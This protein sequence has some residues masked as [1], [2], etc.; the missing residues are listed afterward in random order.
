MTSDIFLF[1]TLRYRPLLNLVSGGEVADDRLRPARLPDYSVLSVN[2]GAFPILEATAGAWAPGD[3][4]Q[5]VTEE[6]R[7]RLD[8]FELIFDY[9]LKSKI[10]EGDLKALVYM[11]P[12]GRW[13]GKGAWVVQD[14]ADR[15]GALTLFA[16]EE[17]MS[18]YD[19]RSPQDVAALMPRITARAA[20]RLRAQSSKH[21]AGTLDGAIERTFTQRAYSGFFAFDQIKACYETFAGRMSDEITREIFIGTDAAIVLPY[22]PVRDRVLLVEQ[23]RMGLWGRGDK[24]LWLMEP[25]AGLVDAG[26]T[27]EDCA[28]REAQEEA[29]LTLTRLEPVAEAYASPGSVTD[30]FYIYVGLCDLPDDVTGTGGLASEG[31]DIR[32]HILSFDALM[33]QAETLQIGNAPMAT[34]IYWLAHHRS[35]LRSGG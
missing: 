15:F 4:L 17:V 2:D 12:K 28:F 31:E 23:V 7:A 29:G 1:G 6:E 9:S 22:D 3:L 32:S 20:S 16:A 30:F 33:N 26:E 18:Y 25:I 27:P 24:T 11:P 34:A 10:L 13:A 35:R 19:Q 14:W 5:G 8:F 21:G